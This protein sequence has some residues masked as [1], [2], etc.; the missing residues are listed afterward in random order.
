[1]PF[2]STKAILGFFGV[3]CG[4]GCGF[5]PGSTD[6]GFFGGRSWSFFCAEATKDKPTT[7]IK[8]NSNF[9]ITFIALITFSSWTNAYRGKRES[10]SNILYCNID[11]TV[12]PMQSQSRGFDAIR[13]K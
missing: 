12:G 7:N 13:R 9:V 3:G 8:L 5:L 6:G 1:M 11:A 4:V 2:G 10:A